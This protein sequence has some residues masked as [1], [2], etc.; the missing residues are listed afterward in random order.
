[1]TPH[2][3]D[4]TK[5]LARIDGRD[6][7]GPSKLGVPEEYGPPSTKSSESEEGE[8]EEVEKFTPSSEKA[9]EAQKTKNVARGRRSVLERGAHEKGKAKYIARCRRSVVAKV[10]ARS[11]AHCGVH[12][13]MGGS[14][15]GGVVGKGSKNSR[16]ARRTLESVGTPS[17]ATTSVGTQWRQEQRRFLE[18]RERWTQ[19]QRRLLE[20]LL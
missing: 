3:S 11:L 4:T 15:G 18:A 7:L 5:H 1:M 19:E 6:K 20:E 9:T 8:D 17:G 2:S 12:G 14:G 10:E 16:K 13:G